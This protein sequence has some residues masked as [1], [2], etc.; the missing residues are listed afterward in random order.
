VPVLCVFMLGPGVGCTSTSSATS[1]AGSG[2]NAP[3]AQAPSA[4]TPA[5]T[6]AGELGGID[7]SRLSPAARK[8]LQT[9]LDDEFCYCGCP[10][11]AGACLKEHTP[12]R[13]AKRMTLL[14]ASLAQDGVAGVEIINALSRYYQSFR[15][16]RAELK[17][18]PRQCLGSEKAQVTIVE[19][20]DFECPFCAAAK[21]MLESFA[22]EHSAQ[23]RFCYATYPLAAHPNA[24]PAGQA[25]LFARDHGKF[26]QM[27]DLLFEHQDDLGP[28]S[29]RR[30]AESL[31]LDGAAFQ[32][33]LDSGRYVDEL[34][35]MRE[36][37]KAAGVTGTPSLRINGRDF[38]LGLSPALLAHTVDDEL[39][40]IAGHNA[41]VKD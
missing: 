4:S 38:K 36:Q 22:K 14:A 24:I 15:S 31:G 25:A 12:C 20:A 28:A 10:H 6:E 32:K 7:V 26:W 17:I 29:L 18:D 30:L 23:V 2:A 21:P 8:E 37:G 13:H 5:R 16:A 27:H 40:W 3:A 35:A 41:W 33:A 1:P 34:N 11:T 19:F 39:E 9:V